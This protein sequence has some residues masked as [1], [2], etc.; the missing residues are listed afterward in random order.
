M[1]NN[2][3]NMR[4][5]GTRAY[6]HR[7]LSRSPNQNLHVQALGS[8]LYLAVDGD[9]R[10]DAR[11][12]QSGT[13]QVFRTMFT[14]DT[15]FNLVPASDHTLRVVDS[16]NHHFTKLEPINGRSGNLYQDGAHIRTDD[17]RCLT[18]ER[19]R[20]NSG[21]RIQLWP[22]RNNNDSNMRWNGTR[23]YHHRRLSRS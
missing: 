1:G 2:D 17:N 18:V 5:N 4:W 23:A 9:V 7:R 20:T 19:N 21:A 6:H 8:N 12:I 22:C 10:A 16:G 14:D 15:H 3:S 13:R 11:I